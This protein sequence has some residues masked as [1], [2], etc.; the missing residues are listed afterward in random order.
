MN[1]DKR[2]LDRYAILS[3]LSVTLAGIFA[4]IHR[5]YELGSVTLIFIF[6]V[7]IFPSILVL[8]FKHSRNR[9]ALWIYGLISLGIVI[10]FGLVDG[11]FNHIFGL[12]GRYMSFLF[13]NLHGGNL[14]LPRFNIILEGTAILTFVASMFVLY[15]NHRFIGGS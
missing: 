12:L 7:V 1:N 3:L 10:V 11:L 6:L 14:P 4:L 13:R 9:V 15:Y 5:Y 2:N 8:W